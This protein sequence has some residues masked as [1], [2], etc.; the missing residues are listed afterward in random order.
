MELCVQ[1]REEIKMINRKLISY[2]MITSIIHDHKSQI[3]HKK[4]ITL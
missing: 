3:I 4:K 2:F 1:E